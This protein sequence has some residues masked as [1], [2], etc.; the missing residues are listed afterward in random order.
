M[1]SSDKAAESDTKNMI[2][3]TKYRSCLN[4]ENHVHSVCCYVIGSYDKPNQRFSQVCHYD[5]SMSMSKYVKNQKLD[6]L[7]LKLKPHKN[8]KKE[9]MRRGKKKKNDTF[10][11]YIIEAP[12][13]IAN[14]RKK[15]SG[16][17][18]RP[19]FFSKKTLS[20]DWE[21]GVQL[22]ALLH[23]IRQRIKCSVI[24]FETLLNTAKHDKL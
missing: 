14:D 3:R 6:G 20:K 15:M 17:S 1:Q 7:T 21:I 5:S 24:N 22:I 16:Y 23:T 18:K 13:I 11:K 8:L 2:Y 9:H 19:F 10:I 4:V 12:F